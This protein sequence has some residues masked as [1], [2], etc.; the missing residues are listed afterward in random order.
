[1]EKLSEKAAV[2]RTAAFFSLVRHPLKFRLYLLKNLPSAFLSGLTVVHADE[3]ACTVMV[4]YKW[5]TRNPFR[6]TY[7]ACLAM[8]AELSTGVLAM[9]QV[10]GRRPSV[11]MLVTQLHGSFSKKATGKT[12]FRCTEG[13]QIRQAVEAVIET[14][15]PQALAVRSVGYTE[16]GEAVAEFLITWSFKAKTARAA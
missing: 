15:Q 4:P 11:S 6:S 9:A 16:D 8:A 10:Y 13:N 7:F 1:M 14:G 2:A 12:H 5:F 3:A